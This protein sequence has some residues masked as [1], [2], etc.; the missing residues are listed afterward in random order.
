MW[1]E[2]HPAVDHAECEHDDQCRE[3]AANAPA[4]EIDEIESSLDCGVQDDS[5]DQIPGND[6]KYIDPDEAAFERRRKR[7]K[8]QNG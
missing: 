7:V 3:D 8:S 4:V 2:H 1:Q 5:G 6:E